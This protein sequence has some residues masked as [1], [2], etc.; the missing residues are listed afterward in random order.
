[1]A[2]K[3]YLVRVLTISDYHLLTFLSTGIA[4]QLSVEARELSLNTDQVLEAQESE[5]LSI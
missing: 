5:M 1:M 3:C 2:G 4:G